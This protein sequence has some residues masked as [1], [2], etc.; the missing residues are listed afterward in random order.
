[1]YKR[2]SLGIPFALAPLVRLSSDRS[3]MG[4]YAN[5][6]PVKTIAWL[7]VALIVSLNVL[8]IVLT[9]SGSA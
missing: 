9:V 8:L 5:S 6:L 1:M 2:Q 4:E 3:I 7:V